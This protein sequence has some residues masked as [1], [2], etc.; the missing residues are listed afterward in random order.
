MK[1]SE[2]ILLNQVT[3]D[4][5]CTVDWNSMDGDDRIR[6]CGQCS[7]NVYNLSALSDREAEKLL[8]GSE[9]RLCL[10]LY[11]RPD[12][13]VITDNCPVGLR[14]IRNRI[15]MQVAV[16][17]ALLTS[18][19]FLSS[20][21]AQGLI[22]A[23]V[24]PTMGQAFYSADPNA[25]IVADIARGDSEKLSW[26]AV[27]TTVVASAVIFVNRRSSFAVLGFVLAVVMLSAG[28]CVG[29]WLS[30]PPHLPWI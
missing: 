20:A 18:V 6:F 15:R 23:P 1:E 10:R 4:T 12:G 7:M 26:S 9:G 30:C 11:R 19:S 17:L 28:A 21:Q 27:M 2:K 24:S 29:V 3:I 16:V 8:S 13:T 5:P 14:K 25:G 22:G